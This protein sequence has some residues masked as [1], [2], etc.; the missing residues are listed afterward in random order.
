[1]LPFM[2]KTVDKINALQ[3]EDF[4]RVIVRDEKSFPY[5]MCTICRGRYDEDENFIEDGKFH[6]ECF[7]YEIPP[8]TVRDEVFDTAEDALAKFM[9]E[10]KSLG[11]LIE[12][13]DNSQDFIDF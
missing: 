9:V 8:N 4:A 13:V 3:G 6:V 2:K 11:E 12:D 10:G 7:D 5:K 1:M